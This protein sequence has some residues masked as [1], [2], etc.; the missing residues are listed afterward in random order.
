MQGDYSRRIPVR[1]TEPNCSESM[2]MYVKRKV[3]RWK[4]T[5]IQLGTPPS[6]SFFYRWCPWGLN[7]DN[8]HSPFKL[9]HVASYFQLD[10]RVLGPLSEIAFEIDEECRASFVHVVVPPRKRAF[11]H[12]DIGVTSQGGDEHS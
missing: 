9:C 5:G 12:V 2:F 7:Q 6:F 1:F 4:M 3:N 10:A 11:S 8:K